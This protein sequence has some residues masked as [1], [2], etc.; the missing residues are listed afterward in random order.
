MNENPTYMYEVKTF[1]DYQKFRDWLINHNFG[2]NVS[3]YINGI[4]VEFSDQLQRL[5]FIAGMQEGFRISKEEGFYENI[6]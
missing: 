1:E 4:T 6:T 2:I 3:V 5:M